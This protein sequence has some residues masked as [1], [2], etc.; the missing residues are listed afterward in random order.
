MANSRPLWTHRDLYRAV[1][2][3]ATWAQLVEWLGP[4]HGLALSPRTEAEDVYAVIPDRGGW[5]WSSVQSPSD[6]AS[7]IR[8][9]DPWP[10]A[11]GNWVMYPPRDGRVRIGCS[12]ARVDSLERLF[13]A[14]DR[15][16]RTSKRRRESVRVPISVRSLSTGL[17]FRTTVRIDVDGSMSTDQSATQVEPADVLR[18]R[19]LLKTARG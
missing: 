16:I 2:V 10:V 4:P 14:R 17:Q 1:H 13:A 6:R 3:R 7:S 12:T 18:A 15:V 11:V 9:G 19:R 5:L 8:P